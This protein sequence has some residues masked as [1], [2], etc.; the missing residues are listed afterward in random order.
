MVPLFEGSANLNRK[1]TVITCFYAREVVPSPH[2][3]WLRY[4]LA[5]EHKE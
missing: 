5:I 2:N 3:D 4:S 1:R